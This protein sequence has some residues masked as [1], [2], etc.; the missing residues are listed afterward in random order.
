MLDELALF[1][2]GGGSLLGS[3]I[4]GIRTR[5]AC[6][7]DAAARGTLL[8]RQRDSILPPF[9]VWDDIRTFNGFEWRGF[10]DV[11]SGGFPCTDISPA[12]KRAGIEGKKSGLW[13]EMARVIGEVRPS[14]VK[15]EN[16]RDLVRRGL[17]V[18]L[19]DLAA[20]GYDARW[21]VIGAFHVGAPHRRERLWL[22]AYR[23]DGS[24]AHGRR[25]PWIEELDGEPEEIA[26]EWERG[27]DLGRFRYDVPNAD[28]L[29]I[30]VEPWRGGGSERQDQAV[31]G[32]GGQDGALADADRVHD[33]NGRHDA[34]SLGRIESEPAELSERAEDVADGGCRRR[35]R[36]EGRKDEQSRG[37]EALGSSAS[38]LRDGGSS[39]ERVVPVG[40]DSDAHGE[41]RSGRRA[42]REAERRKL[43]KEAIGRAFTKDGKPR[44]RPASHAGGLRRSTGWIDSD[45]GDEWAILATNGWWQAEPGM[46]R[47]VDGMAGRVDRIRQNGNGQVPLV[48]A[49]AWALLSGLFD[50][51][52]R[53]P[54]AAQGT[55]GD[56]MTR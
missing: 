6:E 33:D 21:G 47:V 13:S 8:R 53:T 34:S 19:G 37:T 10:I 26:A 52:E 5:V 31:I 41:E 55:I 3:E 23:A 4:T 22:C 44:S 51:D 45:A 24:D 27:G 1:G 29:P 25:L 36:E 12:G 28:G 15:V 38:G 30:W 50:A 35:G 49:I 39:R 42:S 40:D 17:A 9:P 14:F 32:D 18:V 54:N 20:L 7:I 48:E 43:V 2:G 16:S 46:G 56:V 11:V